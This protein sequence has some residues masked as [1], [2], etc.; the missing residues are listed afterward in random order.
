MPFVFNHIFAS[1]ILIG[2]CQSVAKR[3]PNIIYIL[4]DDLG[5]GDISALNSKS[6]ISTP[7]MDRLV[8]EGVHFSDAHSNSSVCT[9][10]RYGILTGRYAW[11][12]RLKQGVLWAYDKPLIEEWRYTA[13]DFLKEQGYHTAVIGKWHLGIDWPIKDNNKPI[14]DYDQSKQYDETFNS[15]IDYQEPV[16]EGPNDLGFDYSFIIPGSLD[17]PPYVY[18]EN[19]QTVDLPTEFT[20]G[21][22]PNEYGRGVYWRSGEVSPAFVFEDAL[23]QFTERAVEYI[24]NKSKKSDPFFL[25][26]P[27]TAPHTPWLPSDTNKSKSNAGRYGDF[28][29]TVDDAVG[30]ILETLDALGINDNTL[31][32]VTSD[33]GAHW[34]ASDKQQFEHRAN[35]IYRGQKADIYEGG[36][37]V[38]YIARY[39]NKIP[40]ETR[41]N[42]ILCTTDFMATLA[43]LLDVPL[44]DGVAEDS[45]NL[46]SAH[47]GEKIEGQIRD[48]TIHHSL[49][50]LYAIRIGGWKLAETLGSGGFTQPKRLSGDNVRG[51]LYNLKE[52]PSEKL[53][54]YND[55]PELV[56]EMLNKLNETRNKK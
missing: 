50:G 11:R 40:A 4:A 22:S 7:N 48:Y 34:N 15:N 23:P 19:G 2:I 14:P 52:D 36:H 25:Y 17:L 32:I 24:K 33:N 20:H 26:F 35:Y 13:A 37:R 46:W 3:P 54:L 38:P 55:E 28:V 10:T 12:S 16:L 6:G 5:Y 41:S 56:A 53:N 29:M 18:L 51:S 39:P 8:Y 49:D 47:I 45:Y 9:P 30:Q 42:Q 43:G 1:L 27:L 31:I 21:R 44:P